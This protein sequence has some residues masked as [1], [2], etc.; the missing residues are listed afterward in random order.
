KSQRC[1]SG[2]SPNDRPDDSSPRSMTKARIVGELGEQELLL[3]ALVNQALLANDRAKYLMTLLQAAREHADH[4]ELAE[5]DLR[6]ERL[7]CGIAETEFDSVAGRS[8]K[9][10]RDVYHI[11]QA[12]HIHDHLIDDVRRMLAPVG[13]R[14]SDAPGNGTAARGAGLPSPPPAAYEKR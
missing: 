8:R 14:P 7:A 4:P 3:P 10:G 5:T 2:P 1:V 6:Q 12:R 13:A 11:P 9:E